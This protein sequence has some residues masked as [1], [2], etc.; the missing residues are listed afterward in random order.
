MKDVNLRSLT[1][2]RGAAS[3]LVVLYHF[4]H[5]KIP[6]LWNG[7]LAVDLFF[8]LS[9]F[10]MTMVYHQ[11]IGKGVTSELY[12]R[13]LYHRFARIFPL[14]FVI[15][16]FMLWFFSS[17]GKTIKI[18]DVIMN[19][20]ML[21]SIFNFSYVVASWS[22]S[23][24]ILAY[25]AFPLACFIIMKNRFLS[26]PIICLCFIGICYL[27]Y[28]NEF[29]GSGPLDIYFGTQAIFRGILSFF[30]GLSVFSLTFGNPPAIVKVRYIGDASL[31]LMVICLYIK[32]MDVVFV[33]LSAFYICTLYHGRSISQLVLS[34]KPLFFL[35]EISFSLY[36][37]HSICQRQYGGYIASITQTY[38][39]WVPLHNVVGMTLIA[40]LISVLTYLIIEKPCRTF[41]R[42]YED[43]LVK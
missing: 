35:G 2:I 3:L 31:A 39:P 9:G 40:L 42:R 18:N 23:V 32:G 15:L 17:T 6:F 21:Q 34:S 10:I 14:Y 37:I 19:L 30:I 13:F 24:E 4:T 22:V 12:I 27:P 1:G 38:I 36:L 25:I 20:F 5:A 43:S 26:V 8:V 41:L 7:Y 33:A 28:M 29:K 16:C 11:K